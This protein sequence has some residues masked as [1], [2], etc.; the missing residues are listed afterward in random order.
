MTLLKKDIR[1][2]KTGITKHLG[3]KSESSSKKARLMVNTSGFQDVV[4]GTGRKNVLLSFVHS[5]V[6]SSM[7]PAGML[8]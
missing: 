8:R 2:F 7:K 5:L 4:V 1:E 3:S 6:R